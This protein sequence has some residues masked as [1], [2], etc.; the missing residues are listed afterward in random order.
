MIFKYLIERNGDEVRL[1]FLLQ[2][3]ENDNF[4]QW[5]LVEVFFWHMYFVGREK[6]IM[7]IE[8]ALRKGNNII[9]KGKFGIGRTSLIKHFAHTQDQWQFAFVDFTRPPGIM[10]NHIITELFSYEKRRHQYVKYKAA[11]FQIMTREL[12]D[13]KKLVLV[14]DNIARITAPKL[15]LLRYLTWEKRFLFIGIVENFLPHID[16]FQLRSLLNP[17]IMIALEHLTIKDGIEFFNRFSKKNQL[18]LA[19]S[20]ISGLAAS[21]GG[22]PLRMKEIALREL[23]R[24][25]SREHSW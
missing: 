6:E 24:C 5:R 14:L 12:G 13:R 2:S 17:S 9:V 25:T 8:R 18:N 10:C 7:Q 20:Q 23:E 16:L 4:Y 22:Y 15:D 11:R 1:K 19:E 21:A 3:E